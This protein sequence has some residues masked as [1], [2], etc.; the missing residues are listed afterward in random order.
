MKYGVCGGDL[1]TK[2]G[3]S[4]D[5]SLIFPHTIGMSGDPFVCDANNV[6]DH[7]N[8]PNSIAYNYNSNVNH[9][10]V[11]V[12]GV[13]GAEYEK[14]YK[15][16]CNAYSKIRKWAFSAPLFIWVLIIQCL[17]KLNPL[18]KGRMGIIKPDIPG[19]RMQISKV[20]LCQTPQRVNHRCCCSR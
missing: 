12:T 16:C 19:M 6:S 17:Q 11:E 8:V 2:F 20:I 5:S 14:N 1:N 13:L 15:G 10:K 18:H 7:Y 9:V 4:F 3:S